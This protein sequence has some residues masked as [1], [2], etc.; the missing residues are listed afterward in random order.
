MQNSIVFGI[1]FLFSLTI[2][3]FFVMPLDFLHIQHHTTAMK[4]GLLTVIA[5]FPLT[6]AGLLIFKGVA[7]FLLSVSFHV[8]SLIFLYRAFYL[9]DQLSVFQYPWTESGGS[10]A[11]IEN[12]LI[13]ILISLL[14]I[15]T[16]LF[17]LRSKKEAE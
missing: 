13:Y 10:L 17:L 6:I 14:G 3:L 4:L 7:V 12:F 8:V 2:Y 15:I 16:S 11:G 9:E 5:I 1:A